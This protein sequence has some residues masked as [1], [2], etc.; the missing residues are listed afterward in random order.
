M[1]VIGAHASVRDSIDLSGND[2]VSLYGNPIDTISTGSSD[3]IFDK[4]DAHYEIK[5]DYLEGI[6][7][8][9]KN[10]ITIKKTGETK[11]KIIGIS[12]VFEDDMTGMNFSATNGAL[13]IDGYRLNWTGN[14]DEVKIHRISVDSNDLQQVIVYYADGS[15]VQAPLFVNS[16]PAF[17]KSQQITLKSDDG[18]DIYYTTDGTNPTL[19]SNKYAQPFDITTGCT[20]K[21]IAVKGGVSSLVSGQN[22]VQQ[23]VVSTIAD[24]ITCDQKT[25]VILQLNNAKVLAAGTQRLFIK[26]ATGCTELA[27]YDFSYKQGDVLNGTVY[28]QSNLA[29]D[30]SYGYVNDYSFY[31]ELTA[32]SG[33]KPVAETVT[34]ADASLYNHYVKFE[35]VVVKSEL[36]WVHA[37]MAYYFT[38]D[39]KKIYLD[40]SILGD[41]AVYEDGK[42]YSPSG[43]LYYYDSTNMALLTFKENQ[44]SGILNIRQSENLNSP[45][46]TIDGRRAT[47][48]LRRGVIYIQNGKKYIR[49]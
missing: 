15:S 34:K 33:E 45:I 42:T 14:S 20:V 12:L 35:N 37:K 6:E 27:G 32:N 44:A 9:W 11:G 13:Y 49:K 39:S 25:D 17:G 40:G 26:D 1:A 16:K 18:G 38:I 2:Y 19:S 3:L 21:A 10:N 31:N 22:F 47:D 28:T 23:K 5:Y 30:Y 36:D 48:N 29:G 7:I 41:D 8:S 43:I 24:F 46:Y 4:G